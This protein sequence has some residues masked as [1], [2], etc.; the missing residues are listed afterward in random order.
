MKPES[1]LLALV[2]GSLASN[3]LA[4]NPVKTDM[5]TTL[6]GPT[7]YLGRNGRGG[8]QLA[9]DMEGGKPGGTPRRNIWSRTG[10]DLT[11]NA[12]LVQRYVGI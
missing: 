11:C 4:R 6:S 5:I 2:A 3:A 10:K 7:G 9:I 8:L 1:S 12:E